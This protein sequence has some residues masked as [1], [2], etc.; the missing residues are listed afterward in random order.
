MALPRIALIAAIAILLV[1]TS[2]V[3]ADVAFPP[4]FLVDSL[5]LDY[6]ANLIAGVSLLIATVL[7]FFC[8]RRAGAP[9]WVACLIC[10]LCYTFANLAL[11]SYKQNQAF[12]ERLIRKN[13]P[14]VTD[15][16]GR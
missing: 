14:R 1:M 7:L 10:L 2:T 4:T 15:K 8:L 3:R 5:Y 9:R 11:Y 16:L 12:Q 6:P 13:D